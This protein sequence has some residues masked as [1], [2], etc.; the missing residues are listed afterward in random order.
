MTDRWADAF[1]ALTR[2]LEQAFEAGFTEEDIED[3]IA[4]ARPSDEP[5]VP[6]KPKKGQDA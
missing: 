4:N 3:A 6:G 2:A 5:Y 1:I